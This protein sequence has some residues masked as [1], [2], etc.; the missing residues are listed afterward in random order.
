MYNNF[1]SFNKNFNSEGTVNKALPILSN[2]TQILWLL[3]RKKK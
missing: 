2:E 1:N 3:M